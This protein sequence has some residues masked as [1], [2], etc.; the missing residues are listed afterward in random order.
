[1]L[2]PESASD[3]AATAA[4][5][6]A[7]GSHSGIDR[8]GR[9][10]PSRR[11]C[12]KPQCRAFG[13]DRKRS[14]DPDGPAA[15]EGQRRVTQERLCEQETCAGS[16]GREVC[17]PARRQECDLGDPDAIEKPPHLVLD[18]LGQ[19]SDDQQRRPLALGHFGHEG[20]K[21][22]IFALRERRLDAAARVGEDA[23]ARRVDPAETLR[24]AR[25]IELDHLGR[26]GTDKKEQADLGPTLEKTADDTVEFLVRV[27]EPSQIALA[28][29]RGRESGLGEDHDASRRLQQ[30][31]TSPGSND[32]KEGILDLAMQPDDP[33]QAAEDFTL[34]TFGRGR[35]DGA[36]TASG[37][38]R[39]GGGCHRARP[40]M[41]GPPRDHLV[42][43]RASR[44]FSRNC[45]ALIA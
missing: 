2:F 19:G 36:G 11:S 28:E 31:R 34:A 24:S 18:H 37:R 43:W 22:C 32:Q 30:M 25:Q 14:A 21:A 23:N 4:C 17:G 10:A 8:R 7:I 12:L 3:L 33:G 20:R 41:F 5:A 13:T 38:G 39:G 29:D 35:H 40:G 16:D 27:G 44:S 6:R 9:D 42:S 1:M 15:L 26:A 45:V